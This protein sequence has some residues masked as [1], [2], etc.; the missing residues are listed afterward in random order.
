MRPLVAG[1]RS[2]AP[3]LSDELCAKGRADLPGEGQRADSAESEA[4]CDRRPRKC[5]IPVVVGYNKNVA[6]SL[7]RLCAVPRR[8]SASAPLVTLEKPAQR[9]PGQTSAKGAES[10]RRAPEARV[11]NASR[12]SPLESTLFVLRRPRGLETLVGGVVIRVPS[13]SANAA[14]A[15]PPPTTT[16]APAT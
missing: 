10:E 3:R 6:L 8:A 7:S 9:E 11:L 12:R 1:R 13:G 4:R 15:Q 14:V 2:D 5:N 16:A